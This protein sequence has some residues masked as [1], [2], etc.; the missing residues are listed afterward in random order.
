M[1]ATL[2]RTERA[3]AHYRRAIEPQPD[4]AEAHFNLGTALGFQQKGSEAK[5]HFLAALRL[6]P[7]YYEA[8]FNLARFHRAPLYRVERAAASD[9]SRGPPKLSFLRPRQTDGGLKSTGPQ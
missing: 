8:H 7:E 3:V 5:P 4:M 1:L 9:L 2:G 6:N